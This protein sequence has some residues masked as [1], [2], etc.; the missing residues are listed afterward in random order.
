VPVIGGAVEVLLV[1]AALVVAVGIWLRRERR[2][3]G[4]RLHG[5]DGIDREELEAAEREVRDLD[6]SARP[7]DDRPGDDWGPGAA[8]PPLRR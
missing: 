8:R 3:P 1:S 4:P 7:G 5:S 2:H 6:P